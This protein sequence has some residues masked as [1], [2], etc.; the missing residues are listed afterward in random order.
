MNYVVTIQVKENDNTI[1]VEMTATCTD[2]QQFIAFI[3]AIRNVEI[4]K[5]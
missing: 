4:S 3:D 5:G 2:I 1:V